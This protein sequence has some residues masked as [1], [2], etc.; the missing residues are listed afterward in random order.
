MS[1][2]SLVLDIETLSRQP[3]A[4]VISIGVLAFHR[5]SFEPFDEIEILPGI[6]DQ[7]AAGRHICPQT[8]AFHKRHNTLPPFSGT[9]TPEQAVAQL[10]EFI[11][12]HHPQHVW[13]QGPDFDRPI[14]Q[15]LCAQVQRELPWEYWRTRDARTVWDLAFPG[16]KHESR[17]HRALD[18][19]RATLNDLNRALTQLK[20]IASA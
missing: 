6:Y 2:T 9:T 20:A 8:I 12:S 14:L 3:D 11:A 16:V 17:P 4:V 10:T 15:N 5:N 7:I 13:I 19:C 18:D 1:S